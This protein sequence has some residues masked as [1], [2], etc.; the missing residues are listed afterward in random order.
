M[1]LTTA[2][3]QFFGGILK[4]LVAEAVREAI[5]EKE[6]KTDPDYITVE[7]ACEILHCSEPTLYNRINK[8]EIKILKNGRSSLINKRKLIED[9]ESGKLKLRKDKH[10]KVKHEQK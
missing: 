6:I 9:L 8:G 2:I 10:R 5:S 4:P 1:E 7:K 3:E